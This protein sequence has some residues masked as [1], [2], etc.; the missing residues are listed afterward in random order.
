MK[1]CQIC[2]F[3]IY[4]ML[5]ILFYL[6]MIETLNFWCEIGSYVKSVLLILCA[7]Y[8]VLLD[9]DGNFEFLVYM[10]EFCFILIDCLLLV[11]LRMHLEIT[12]LYSAI[13][14]SYP[15][16]GRLIDWMVFN[17]NFSSISPK[18]WHPVADK[19][20]FEVHILQ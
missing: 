10:G 6:I 16:C 3:N 9:N 11:V 15:S 1:L 2:P 14:V 20:E 19:E 4:F 8:F 17:P 18:S 7:I 13:L 5:C 12:F